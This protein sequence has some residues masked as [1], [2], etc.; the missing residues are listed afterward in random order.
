VAN[1]KI[2]CIDTVANA[3]FW[4]L[5]INN[6]LH[7]DIAQRMPEER[8]RRWQSAGAYGY[9]IFRKG[10]LYQNESHLR[11]DISPLAL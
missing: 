1:L 7:N 3:K 11:N 4:A 6:I 5:Q 9:A 10:F 2:P 8:Q